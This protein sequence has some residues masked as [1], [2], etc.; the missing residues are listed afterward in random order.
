[1]CGVDIGRSAQLFTLFFLLRSTLA[2][3]WMDCAP[4][5]EETKQTRNRRSAGSRRNLARWYAFGSL[6]WTYR[7]RECK[8]IDNRTAADVR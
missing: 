5:G 4:Q 2:W 6:Y 8:H 3:A 1:M 7:A